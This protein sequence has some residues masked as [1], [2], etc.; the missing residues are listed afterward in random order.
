MEAIGFVIKMALR[1]LDSMET[2]K[3]RVLLKLRKMV[4]CCKQTII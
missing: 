4:N 3:N 2:I 1:C